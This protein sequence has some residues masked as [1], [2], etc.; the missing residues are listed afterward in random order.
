MLVAR[1]MPLRALAV[2]VGVFLAVSLASVPPG[3]AG[4]SRAAAA[5]VEPCAV[6]VTK[7]ALK[8]SKRFAA[9]GLLERYR[10][11]AD[12]PNG[13]TY[14]QAAK[15]VLT[16]YGSTTSPTTI[17]TKIGSRQTIGEMVKAQEPQATGAI[18]GDFFVRPTILGKRLE[19]ARGPVVR[20]G[21]IVRANR[22]RKRVVGVDTSRDPYGGTL[23]LRGAISVGS[24]PAVN[25]M[26]INWESVP[27]D[28]ASLFTTNWQASS[29]TPRPAG[30]AEWVIDRQNKIVSVRGTGSGSLGASVA[31]GT[32][33]VAFGQNQ[34][35]TATFGRIGDVVKVRVRQKTN[36]G[37]KLQSAIG[38]GSQLVADGVA[39]PRG[40]TAYAYSRASRPRTLVGWTRTGEWR[41]LTVPGDFFENCP[42]CLRNGG[43]AL[44]N[45]AAIAAQLG[46]WQAFELDGGGSTT[47]YT[48]SS[49]GR[50][51]RRDLYGL[52]K[53]TGT[54]ERPVSDGFAFVTP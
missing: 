41:S 17:S 19:I 10:A 4:G 53:T 32:R 6:T 26:G 38:R 37:V 27:S 14:D 43:F 22:D 21:R 29:A 5:T 47:L 35:Q 20:D 7:L 31:N 54:Y 8:S 33:V 46:I 39:A 30:A 3:A 49:R 40:C 44:A 24:Y 13:T 11:A 45:E 2:T 48:R 34:T 1:S 52:D 15:V 25:L 23:A 50:W 16:Q 51:V 9:H 12:Y 28:G 36:S 18:N 42:V